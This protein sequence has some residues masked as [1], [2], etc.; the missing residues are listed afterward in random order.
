MNLKPKML[1]KKNKKK[2]YKFWKNVNQ[3][4]TSD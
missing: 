3:N 4:L 1:H 2:R